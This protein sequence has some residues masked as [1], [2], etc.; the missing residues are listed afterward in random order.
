MDIL[1]SSNLERLLYDLC[2][3]D[4]GIVNSLN[5]D[6]N[7]RGEFRI[8]KK[9][10]DKLKVF[11]G[12]YT[13]DRETFETIKYI[14][15]NFNYLIDTHTAVGYN[16]YQKYIDDTGDNLKTVIASTASPFKFSGSVARA[17]DKKFAAYDDFTLLEKLA[18]ISG[19]KIP[20]GLKGINKRRVIH[21][22]VCRT[23]EM[24]SAVC[25]ILKIKN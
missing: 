22:T 21:T 23:S 14:F 13:T 2:D 25:D 19:F 24:K 16:V 7:E 10:K 6:L 20:E 1:V 9:M 18:E 3:H 15:E 11:Y 8:I 4:A 12:G 17:I 5:R